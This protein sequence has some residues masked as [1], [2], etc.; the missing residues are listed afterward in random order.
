M[1]GAKQVAG[2]ELVDGAKQVAVRISGWGLT[3]SDEEI[4]GQGLNRQ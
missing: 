3:I 1:D 4:G 2:V